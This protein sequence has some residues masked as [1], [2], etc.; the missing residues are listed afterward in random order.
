MK[1]FTDVLTE[2]DDSTFCAIRTL[3]FIGMGLVAAG[4][5][6]S[7]P[8]IEIGAAAAAVVTSVG[9]ALRLKP[10]KPIDTSS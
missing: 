8:V 9:G 1:I 3:G 5:V 2:D 6:L 10:N 4:I 7:A